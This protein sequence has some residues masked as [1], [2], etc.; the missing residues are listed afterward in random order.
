[1]TAIW[2][3]S[4]T[5]VLCAILALFSTISA[6]RNSRLNRKL[7][8]RDHDCLFLIEVEHRLCIKFSSSTKSALAI[9]RD[10]RA[11]VRERYPGLPSAAATP[12]SLAREIA[13]L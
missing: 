5:S 10:N 3:A 13:K 9:K 4:G 8:E 6:H 7:K 12:Y 2:V 11:A 1:V